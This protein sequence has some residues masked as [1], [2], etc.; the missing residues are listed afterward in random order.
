MKAVFLDRATFAADVSLPA[1]AGV[2]D[3][4]VFERSEPAEVIARSCEADIIITNKIVFDAE[5]LAQLPQLKLI[6]ITAT[7]TD[8]V[9]KIAAEKQGIKVFNVSGYSTDSVAEHTLMMILATMRALSAHHRSVASG[10]WIKDGRFSL[11]TPALWDLKGK[12]LGLVGIGSIAHR[13]TE[14]AQAFGMNVLWAE[15]LGRA[16]RDD[17]YTDF[18]TVMAASDVIALHCPLTAETKHLINHQTIAM[19]KRAPILIN[20]ARGAVMEAEAVAQALQKGQLSGLGCDV[21]LPEPP[22]ADNP[23]LQFANHPRVILTPHNAWA[24]FESQQQLWAILSTQVSNFIASS[25]K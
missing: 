18:E 8:N 10:A 12:T 17:R 24:S 14:L 15:R 9:D 22:E 13:V 20:V 4:R 11:S 25:A 16:P 1:P 19:M 2:S 21:F 6:Q 3:W 7:G 23:L 5:L